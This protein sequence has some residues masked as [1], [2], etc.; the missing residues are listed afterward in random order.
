MADYSRYSDQELTTMLSAGSHAAFGEIFNRYDR[1]LY[2]YAYKKLEDKEEA[3][4]LVQ[5]VFTVLWDN[6]EKIRIK[7]SL[8]SYL[9]TALR[10]KALNLF[11]DRNINDKY[12]RS[13]AGFMSMTT[14]TTDH[15]AREANINALIEKEIDGLPEKMREVFRLRR[16]EYLSNKEIALRLGISEQTVATHMKRALKAIRLKL[17]LILYLIYYFNL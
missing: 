10:N 2:I 5:E 6:R 15:L 1:L 8:S 9:Y 17:G 13:L 11:R 4:D 12:L 7:E 16:N 3:K 14:E